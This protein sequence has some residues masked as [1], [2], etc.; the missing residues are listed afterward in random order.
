MSAGVSWRPDVLVPDKTVWL[1]LGPD[2]DVGAWVS[3]WSERLLG[4]GP[5]RKQRKQLARVLEDGAK[6]ARSRLPMKA[7]LIFYPDYTRVPPVANIEFHGLR[8][9]PPNDPLTL[10]FFREVYGTPG[11]STLGEIEISEAGIPAGPALR[12][13]RHWAQ[14]PDWRGVSIEREDVIYAVRPPQI[15]DG[16]VLFVSWVEPAFAE[17]LIETADAVAMTLEIKLVDDF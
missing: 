17:A 2:Q 14:E 12:F 7:G 13:H 11:K 4:G 3:E 15:N 5:D 16:A 6:D 9:R 1:P 10:D 8:P